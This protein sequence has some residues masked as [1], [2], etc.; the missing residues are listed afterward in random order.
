MRALSALLSAR[1]DERLLSATVLPL[2]TVSIEQPST[3]G[4][5]PPFPQQYRQEPPPFIHQAGVQRIR[6]MQG[7]PHQRRP[8][9]CLQQGP[10]PDK[11][12]RTAPTRA[13]AE[14]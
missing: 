7:D 4:N 6:R 12:Q 2:R 8:S 5:G 13:C 11:R 1:T 9:L 10:I 14:G 3:L